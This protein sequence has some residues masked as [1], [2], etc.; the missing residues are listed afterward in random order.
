MMRFFQEVPESITEAAHIDGAGHGRML[1]HIILPLSKAGVATITMF[2]AVLRWNEYFRASIFI[3]DSART[4]LQ[5][6]LRQ[7]VVLNDTVAILGAQNLLNYND[8]AKLD[9]RAVQCA[10]IVVAVIP[11]LLLYPIVLKYYTKDIMGGGVKE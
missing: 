3:I 8:V 4:T 1:W 5:V 10:C 9:Y 11:I 6:I 2:Y 7:F